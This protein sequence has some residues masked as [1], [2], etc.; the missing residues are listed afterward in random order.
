LV[1]SFVPSLSSSFVSCLS[2]S[3]D[4]A[5]VSSPFALR[6]GSVSDLL[7]DWD[8]ESLSGSGLGSEESELEKKLE[9]V[10]LIPRAK[11]SHD[12]KEKVT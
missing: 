9:M 5:S 1:S 3:S 11:R 8:W 4:L 7:S 12:H 2:L 6:S 10:S